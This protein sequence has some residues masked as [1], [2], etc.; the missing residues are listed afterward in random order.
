M[1]SA[2]VARFPS[3]KGNS[4]RSKGDGPN[5]KTAQSKALEEFESAPRLSFP[6]EEVETRVSGNGGIS[7]LNISA[8]LSMASPTFGTLRFFASQTPGLKKRKRGFVFFRMQNQR[9]TRKS[10]SFLLEHFEGKAYQI[11]EERGHEVLT[12]RESATKQSLSGWGN[13]KVTELESATL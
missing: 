12:R 7:L 2:S 13:E 8:I 4:G 9:I 10:S 1:G 3:C 6:R 11:V 5:A